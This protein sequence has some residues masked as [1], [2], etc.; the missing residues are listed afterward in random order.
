MSRPAKKP[1]I[2]AQ[3]RGGRLVDLLAPDFTHLDL[4]EDIARPLARIARFAGATM[5]ERPWTV[6]QHS[7]VGA[8]ALLE[9]TG[10]ATAALAF[11]VHDAHEVFL[12]DIPR[13]A[14]CALDH[15]VMTGLRLTLGPIAAEAAV[16]QA[17]GSFFAVALAGFAASL[18]RA[19]HRLAGLPPEL[20]KPLRA[21]VAEMDD[22]MLRTELSDQMAPTKGRPDQIAAAW[23]RIPSLAPIRRRGR[24]APWRETE[25]ADRWLTRFHQWR[26]APISQ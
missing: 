16:R 3:T 9:E 20:P 18:D 11:L 4:A 8:E 6:A 24:L 7:V 14:A 13:P 19:V 5:G 22:R 17:G 12:G 2:Y 25:A 21:A 10:D 1:A 15:Y 26:I 23:G